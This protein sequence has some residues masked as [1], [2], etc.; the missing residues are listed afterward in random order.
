[1]IIQDL[2]NLIGIKS[3]D[4]KIVQW[5]E[6]H[7]LGTPPKTITTNQRDKDFEDKQNSIRY[8]FKF[9]IINDKFYPPVSPKN[10]QYKFENYLTNISV[11]PKSG[12]GKKTDPKPSDFWEGFVHPGSS[13]EECLAYFDHQSSSSSNQIFFQKPLNDITKIKVWFVRDQME[14]T[15]IELAL[16]EAGEI[17]SHSSFNPKNEFNTVQQSYLLLAKWL[18]DHKYLHLPEDIYSHGL[19]FDQSEILTFVQSHLKNHIWDTQLK[20]IPHLRAFLFKISS[21]NSLENHQGEAINFYIKNLY[22]KVAGKWEERQRIYTE[23]FKNVD[24]FEKSIVLNLTQ[25]QQFLAVLTEYFGLFAQINK[26]EQ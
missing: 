3:T 15:A 21:N 1:M 6:Q 2:V 18:F 24:N 22:L 19:T 17:F 12:K 20:P 4:P 13:L 14:I 5:F 10:D 8:N 11:F 7:N 26:E 25:S 23:D 16:I 9:K